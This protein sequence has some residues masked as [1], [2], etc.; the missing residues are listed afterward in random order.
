[1][2]V[3]V[4]I[5][6]DMAS[7]IPPSL[8]E[9]ARGQAG[10]ISRRQ[11]IS[12]GMTRAALEA[13]IASGRWQKIYRGAYATFS[14]PAGWTARVWAAVLYA[15]PGAQLSHET[16]AELLRLTDERR[17]LIHVA[18][19][20]ERRVRPL[21]GVVIHRSSHIEQGWRFARG[22]PP[23]TMV[24]QTLMD[25]L[26]QAANLN[27]A[28]GWIAGAFQR[29]LTNE[30]TLRRAMAARTR[31]RWR[32]RLEAAITMAASG[33][34]SPLEYRYDLDVER[35]H[36]LPSAQKQVPFVKPDGT[37]GFRDRY[38]NQYG[39]IV[40]LD[41]KRY[42]DDRRDHDRRRDNAAAATVGATLRYGWDDVTRGRCQTAAQVHAALRKRG[43]AGT[44][45]PCSPACA[46]PGAS[47]ALGAR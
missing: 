45:R 4:A 37:Q 19:P 31:L 36:A 13:K 23:H 2:S 42:H 9:L 30:A 33:T 15:G 32:D 26:D 25:L 22:I 1:L 18:I 29:N 5:L 11:A 3:R 47:A 17:P 41:G 12:A 38:Y 27:D 35:A 10:V 6:G 39:M 21:D 34:H 16:A 14:G 8:L 46:A 7:D 28:V 20:R 44:L 40:E 43:Y 24:E